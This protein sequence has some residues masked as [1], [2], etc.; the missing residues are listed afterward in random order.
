MTEPLETLKMCELR[1]AGLMEEIDRRSRRPTV[2]CGK[3][4]AEADRPE[5]V[6]NPRPLANKKVDSYWG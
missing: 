3:C 2:K 6:H 5:Q 4:G 1:A